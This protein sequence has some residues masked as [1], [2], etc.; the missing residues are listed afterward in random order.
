MSGCNPVKSRH[1]VHH[2]AL[3]RVNPIGAVTLSNPGTLYTGM[4]RNEAEDFCCNPV[5]SRHPVHPV[6]HFILE[7][8]YAVTLSN[9]GTLYT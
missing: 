5:K 9:P 6:L 3:R 8:L 1:P 2:E 4:S 7:S